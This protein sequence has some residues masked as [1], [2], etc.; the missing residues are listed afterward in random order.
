MLL[1][2]LIGALIIGVLNNVL[3]ILEVSSYYQQV[4]KGT[5]I[6]L[7]VLIDRDFKFAQ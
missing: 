7:T 5:V 4:V 6:L 1:G 2:T 3:N